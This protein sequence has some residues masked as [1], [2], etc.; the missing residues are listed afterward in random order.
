MARFKQAEHPPP[1]LHLIKYYVY[2]SIPEMVGLFYFTHCK[3]KHS[4]TDFNHR[5]STHPSIHSTSKNFFT[6]LFMFILE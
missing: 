3:C 4:T 2:Y 6:S 5:Q 1:I